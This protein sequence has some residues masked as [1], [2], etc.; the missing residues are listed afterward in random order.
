MKKNELEL[1]FKYIFNTTPP[2]SLKKKELEDL[3]FNIPTKVR[4]NHQGRGDTNLA[5]GGLKDKFRKVMNKSFNYFVKKKTIENTLKYRGFFNKTSRN[6]I[7]SYGKGLIKSMKIVRVPV[8][9]ILINVLNYISLGLFKELLKTHGFDK[10][11]HLSLVVTL[12]NGNNIII[13]KLAEVNVSPKF[14]ISKLAEVKIVRHYDSQSTDINHLLDDALKFM[15]KKSFFDYDAFENNCQNFI[16][17]ILKSQKLNYDEYK[18]FIYQDIDKLYKELQEKAG[19][20][21][22][23]AK[24]T[25]RTGVAFNRLIGAGKLDNEK[26]DYE[27][28][29]DLLSYNNDNVKIVGGTGTKIFNYPLKFDLYEKIKVDNPHVRGDNINNFINKFQDKIENILNTNN[30]ILGD[31][32]IGEIEEFKI[33]NDE[34]YFKDNKAIIYIYDESL[35]KLKNLNKLKIINDDEYKNGL[36]ILKKNPSKNEFLLMKDYFRYHILRWSPLEIIEGEKNYRNFKITLEEAIKTKGIF[37][38]DAIG[39][40]DELKEFSIL[41]DLRDKDNKRL[42]NYL[43]N[44]NDNLNNKI[45]VN[46]IKEEYFEGLKI[47]YSLL[48]Y[49]YK[50]SNEKKKLKKEMQDLINFFNNNKL[51]DNFLLD[52]ESLIFLLKSE[53]FIDNDKLLN[54]IDNFKFRL[55]NKYESSLRS[56]ESIKKLINKLKGSFSI[57][58]IKPLRNSINKMLNEYSLK[59]IEKN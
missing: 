20:V 34:A 26:L 15:G 33:L 11:F 12:N 9:K 43:V 25:T 47:L 3:I 44:V 46:F 2:K 50:Y 21:S 54:S 5:G 22:T 29:I 31:I 59:Y 39:D 41:F 49:T 53:D 57:E 10:L 6:A 27:D 52:L 1:I 19:F 4:D 37:K 45:K 58:N 51:L 35:K 7:Y 24:F 40:L 42:N 8:N 18:N 30:I 55:N 36:K 32:K 28:I 16:L 48:K 38:I 23:I 13:E 56:E 17:S 14:K